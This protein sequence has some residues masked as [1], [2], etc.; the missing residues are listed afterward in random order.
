MSFY[1]NPKRGCEFLL[2]S[3]DFLWFDKQ[4]TDQKIFRCQEQWFLFTW[5]YVNDLYTIALDFA[6]SADFGEFDHKYF[7]SEWEVWHCNY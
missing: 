7:D 3:E 6:N 1:E 2:Q 4:D 5:I